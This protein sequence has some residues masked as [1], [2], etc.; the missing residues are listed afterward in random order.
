MPTLRYYR[1]YFNNNHATKIT[2]LVTTK[3][4]IDHKIGCLLVAIRPNNEI[5]TV[6]K[7]FNIASTMI[8]ANSIIG[9]NKTSSTAIV[10]NYYL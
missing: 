4:T 1:N 9:A 7:K 2:A 5:K 8:F 3:Q 10:P 6:V